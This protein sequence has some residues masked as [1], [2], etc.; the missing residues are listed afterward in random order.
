MAINGVF[1]TIISDNAMKNQSQAALTKAMD[2]ANEEAKKDDP[3]GV[4]KAKK[5]Q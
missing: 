5:A 1:R 2:N 4:S 3:K